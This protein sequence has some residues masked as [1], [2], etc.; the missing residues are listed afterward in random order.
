MRLT[1]CFSPPAIKLGT[2]FRFVSLSS[3]VGLSWSFLQNSILEIDPTSFSSHYI[4]SIEIGKSNPRKM[5][6]V[7]AEKEMRNYRRIYVAGIPCPKPIFLKSHILLMEFLGTNGWPSPRLKDATLSSKHIR[8]AYVQT[9]LIMRHMYQRCKLVHGDLSEYNLL[10][11]QQQVYVI[12]VSQSVET[13]HPAAL[14]FLRKDSSNVNEFFHKIGKLNVMTTKQLFEF[15][16]TVLPN[17]NNNKNDDD[18]GNKTAEDIEM[19]HL[20]QIM[21]TVEVRYEQL[22]QQ[23]EQVRREQ[24]Q[25]E[26]VEEAVFMSS[27]LPRSLNQVADYDIEQLECGQ[28]EETYAHAVAALTGNPDVV[29]A[30]QNYKAGQQQQQQHQPGSLLQSRSLNSADLFTKTNEDI[31]PQEDIDDD[32]S[33]DDDDVYA[34]SSD[35]DDEGEGDGSQYVKVVRT[36]EQ[37]EEERSEKKAQRKANKK[38]VKEAKAEKRQ[39]K[40]KKKDKKKAIKRAKAGNRKNR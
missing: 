34:N 6:K 15:V 1:C 29:E 22:E 40:I 4:S 26:S 18:D 13:H 27:F 31:H 37:L 23:S 28:V 35:S 20:E 11:H 12:D 39:T 33:V 19:D 7:W 8:E 24:K 25:L 38:A 10:W 3:I 21:K 16:T 14:D 2:N 9:I 32:L 17:P 30:Y 5:V 36:E